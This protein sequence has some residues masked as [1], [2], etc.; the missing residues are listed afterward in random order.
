MTDKEIELFRD[1]LEAMSNDDLL[2]VGYVAG[3]RQEAIEE[4]LAHRRMK[5]EEK[6]DEELLGEDAIE[7]E[8]QAAIERL[9]G[10]MMEEDE[11]R[12]K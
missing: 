2:G 12:H 1:K 5:L 8:R 7:E 4:C 10:A 11:Q 9:V 3:L 6:D